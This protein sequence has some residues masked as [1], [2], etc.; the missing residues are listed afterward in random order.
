M[1]N[2]LFDITNAQNEDNI[3]FGNFL[4]FVFGNIIAHNVV[5]MLDMFLMD[6]FFGNTSKEEIK[7]NNTVVT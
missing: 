7:S 1:L 6:K 3:M 5:N 2:I 4:M